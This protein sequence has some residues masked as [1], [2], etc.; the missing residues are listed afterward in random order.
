[1]V[2]RKRG[3]IIFECACKIFRQLFFILIFFF[4]I[5]QLSLVRYSFIKI[6]VML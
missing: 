1:M 4:S 6:F 5:F 3:L 2:H